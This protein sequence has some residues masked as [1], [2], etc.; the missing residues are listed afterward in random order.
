MGKIT[1]DIES[2]TGTET[3]SYIKVFLKHGGNIMVSTFRIELTLIQFSSINRKFVLVSFFSSLVYM[4]KMT[5]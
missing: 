3:T 5:P 2:N 1:E 4:I